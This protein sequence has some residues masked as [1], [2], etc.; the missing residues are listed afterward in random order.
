[1]LVYLLLP[2]IRTKNIFLLLA[3]IVFYAL[4]QPIYLLLFFWLTLMNHALSHRI[5]PGK[6]ATAAAPIALSI[7]F[8]AIFKMMH[9]MPSLS[10]SEANLAEK[11]V[12]PLGISYYTFQLISYQV[13][14]YC[15]KIAPAQKLSDLLLY[16]FIFPKIITGP[17][18]RYTD[19][20]PQINER[21][22]DGEKLLRG[23]VRFVVGLAKKVLLADHCGEIISQLDTDTSGAGAWL[24]ALLFMFRIYFEFAGCSDMAI[25]MAKMMGFDFCE[26]FNTPYAAASITDFWRRWHMSLSSFFRDYVYIPLGG[27]RK[28]K[29]RQIFNMFIVWALTGLWHGTTLNYLLWGIYFF[30][31]L[32]LEKQFMP[33]LQKVKPWVRWFPTAFLILFGWAIFAGQDIRSLFI[34]DRFFSATVSIYLRN[35]TPLLIACA[36][37][38]SSLFKSLS[39][40]CEGWAQRNHATKILYALILIALAA[41]LLWVSTVSLIGATNAPDIYGGKLR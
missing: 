20:A 10:V 30:V 15:G 29:L 13:D 27:N 33:L 17:I 9:L 11:L 12:L 31:L 38:S 21:T 23:L 7:A 26:N 24:C 19:F 16:A 6:R 3:S 5:I 22:V 25:G 41:A 37:G 36:I 39:G 28:G 1:M 34:F 18:V 40:H 2:G 4:L 14:I 8:L 32:A 35:S